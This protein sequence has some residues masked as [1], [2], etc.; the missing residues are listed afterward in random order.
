MGGLNP[1]SSDKPKESRAVRDARK[2]QEEALNA[3]EAMQR[4]DQI[5]ADKREEELSGQGAAQRRAILARR[6]G[7]NALSFSGPQLKTQLGG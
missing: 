6:R 4:R 3:Q 5:A 2:R 7:R 1:F